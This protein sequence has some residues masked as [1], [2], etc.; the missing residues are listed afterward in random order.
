MSASEKTCAGVASSGEVQG[1][2]DAAVAKNFSGVTRHSASSCSMPAMPSTLAVQSV[3]HNT[4]VLPRGSTARANWVG[5]TMLASM[6]TCASISPG[7][8]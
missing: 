7:D 1:T 8:R 2:P 4:A 3:S 6:W 5:V